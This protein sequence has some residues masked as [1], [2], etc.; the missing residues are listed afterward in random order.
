MAVN[1]KMEKSVLCLKA[2][3]GSTANGMPKYKAYSFANVATTATDEDV[4]AVGVALGGLFQT[5]I[6]RVERH[7]NAMLQSE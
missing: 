7:D 2:Q 4:H 5:A 3:T 1:K 6:S